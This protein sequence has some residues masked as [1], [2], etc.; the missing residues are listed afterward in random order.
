MTS[1]PPNIFSS[2]NWNISSTIVSAIITIIFGAILA[3][4]LGPAAYGIIA[5]ANLTNAFARYF[6]RMGIGP[7]II[8]SGNPSSNDIDFVVTFSMGIG[9]LAAVIVALLSPLVALFFKQPGST[10]VIA[11]MG[12]SLWFSAFSSSISGVLVRNMQF[13]QLAIIR[14]AQ[15]FFSGASSIV[16]AYLG[17]GIWSLVWPLILGQFLGMLAIINLVNRTY[18]LKPR[19]S[20][21]GH[22]HL[23]KFG[24]LYSLNSLLEYFGSNLDTIFVGRLFS[25]FQLGLYN[26][27]FSLAYLPSESLITSITSVMFPVFSRLQSSN[28][29]FIETQNKLF[30]F[31]GLLSSSI[32]M[33]M[34]PAARDITLVLLGSQWLEAI[35]LLMILLFGVP[36]DFMAATIAMTFDAS[37]KL[38][39]KTRIQIVTILILLIGIFLLYPFGTVGIATALVLSSV[40]HFLIYVLQNQKTFSLS[41]YIL[42]WNLT[43]IFLSGMATFFCSKTAAYLAK[44]MLLSPTLA[45]FFEIIA[46]LVVFILFLIVNAPKLLGVKNLAQCFLTIKDFLNKKD[47]III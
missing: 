27:A 20:F 26:R 8:Q 44:T 32:A 28:E 39:E 1:H 30:L 21:A 15:T 2:I 7:A 33:G 34:I 40:I 25:A 11:I 38:G 18:P 46:C 14:L 41:Y 45:L 17:F 42:F 5:I 23:I 19:F 29:K 16:M 37:A 36:F 12:L 3:R 13:K 47:E 35:P 10:P 43:T 4:L 9:F 22:D 6:V 31:I 24:S